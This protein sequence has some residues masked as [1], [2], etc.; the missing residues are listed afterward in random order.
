MKA[1][2]K[3]IVFLLA[4]FLFS[5]SMTTLLN[6]VTATRRW[7]VDDDGPADFHRIQ[8]AID[9]AMPGDI[10]Y[11]LNG[12]YYEN[13]LISK[14][15]SLVGESREATVIDGNYSSSVITIRRAN[16]VSVSGFT[17]RNSGRE[18]HLFN[19]TGVVLYYSSGIQF[20]HNKVTNNEVGIYFY[21]STDNVVKNNIVV[22]NYFYG[23]LMDYSPGPPTNVISNNII[24]GN[25]FGIG[26]DTSF[27]HTITGNIIT[28]STWNGI[29]VFSN[30]HNNT[31][32]ENTVIGAV[33]GIFLQQSNA[34]ALQ[35]NAIYN[36]TWDGVHLLSSS[37]NRVS[38]NIIKNNYRG[39]YLREK[40]HNNTFTANLFSSNA[41]GVKLRNS[42]KN[43][44]YHNNFVNNTYSAFSE[45]STPL[46]NSWDSGYPSGGNYWSEHTGVD[47]YSGP[48]QNVTGSDG[49]GDN[50]YVIASSNIDRYPLIHPKALDLR[51]HDVAVLSVSPSS[52]EVYVGEDVNLTITAQNRGT[53]PENFSVTSSYDLEGS[54]YVIATLNVINLNPHG[55]ITLEVNWQ[56]LRVGV[57]TLKI[58][59]SDLGDINPYDNTSSDVQIKV[60]LTGDINGDGTVDIRDISMAA[61]AY[62][63][64]PGHP[65]WNPQADFNKDG[66]V[67]IRDLVFVAR[68]FGKTA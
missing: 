57:H 44:F 32:T 40:A 62:G 26:L 64:Y 31:L 4:L 56:T 16:N 39:A 6:Q 66:I 68:H 58:F 52:Y 27:G 55:N 63:S 19:K 7:T 8:D 13:I 65:R 29:Y 10:V 49:I 54:R 22:N 33:N 41:F 17:L 50:P 21:V 14:T 51:F 30:S 37:F 46:T 53:F 28:N 38:H 15:L 42:D 61:R 1:L 18:I 59:T 5:A 23:V 2:S 48:Y 3:V 12:T 47:I 45:D 20:Q 43:V 9:A 11:V 60:K 67:D 24:S 34:M 36:V 35:G 25:G